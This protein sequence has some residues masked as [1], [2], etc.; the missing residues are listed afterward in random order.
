MR[1]AEF[2]TGSVSAGWSRAAGQLESSA[3]L[4]AG[5]HFWSDLVTLW[6]TTRRY[7]RPDST[8]AAV[9][10]AFSVLG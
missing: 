1:S 7:V 5:Y 9:R 2:V 8:T 10:S 6:Q 4:L 3:V